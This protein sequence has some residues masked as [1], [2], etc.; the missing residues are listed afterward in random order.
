MTPKLDEAIDR[1]LSDAA[2]HHLPVLEWGV[3]PRVVA[4]LRRAVG[5][6]FVALGGAGV[7]DVSVDRT[8]PRAAIRCGTVSMAKGLGSKVPGGWVLRR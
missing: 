3:P 2:R 8:R 5:V 7:V 4:A 1:R 6:G